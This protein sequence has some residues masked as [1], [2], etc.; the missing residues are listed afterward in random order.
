MSGTELI[1]VQEI[2]AQVLELEAQQVQPDNALLNDL[3]ADSLDIVDVAFSLGKAF[4]LKMPTKTVLVI[5]Q[6]RAPQ[7]PLFQDHR[8]TELGAR[9]LQQGPNLY[10]ADIAK[11]GASAAQV[12]NATTVQNWFE[13]CRFVERHPTRNGDL[14]IA[15]FIAE[16]VADHLTAVA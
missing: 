15:D 9:L 16:F 4:G 10:S 5:A 13:L 8:L 12:L 6:E 3:D 7:L 2:I 14:A 11:A 1:K